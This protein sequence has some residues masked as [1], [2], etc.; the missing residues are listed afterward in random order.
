LDRALEAPP[1]PAPENAIDRSDFGS[2]DLQ[3]SRTVLWLENHARRREHLALTLKV[4]A[5]AVRDYPLWAV[6]KVAKWWS[7]AREGGELRHFL[8][9]VRLAIGSNVLERKRLLERVMGAADR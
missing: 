4:W 7:R 9:D 2:R 1:K 3:T 5:D 8:A 6:Q